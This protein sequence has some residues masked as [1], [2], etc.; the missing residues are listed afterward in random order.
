MTK[1]HHKSNTIEHLVIRSKAE[2][3]T[4][5]NPR[6]AHTH[7][8]TAMRLI[9]FG[10]N[11]L[12]R[13]FPKKAGQI[14]LNIFGTPRSRAQHKVSDDLIESA[15]VGDI[16]IDGMNIKT[17]EW[18]VGK[19]TILLA[20]GWESRGTALRAF[21]PDLVQAGYKVIAFDA[22]A[23]G[24]SE[25]GRATLLSFAEVI[26]HVLCKNTPIHAIIAHSF[27]G[28]TSIYALAQL[29]PKLVIPKLVLIA[30]PS[31]I[32]VP[33][34]EAISMMNL[35]PKAARK[36]TLNLEKIV[37]SSIKELTVPL[38]AKDLKFDN[39]LIIHDQSDLIVPINS[40]IEHSKAFKNAQLL[41][42][43]GLGHYLMLKNNQVVKRVTDF[44]L[45]PS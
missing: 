45:N 8:P 10:F 40:A 44:I 29:E 30:A 11:T 2:K 31:A 21:V 1:P 15:K 42:T 19:K 5:I 16:I 14:A 35:P 24:D 7:L 27:G 28:P 41:T 36:F 37:H 39:V 3:N 18:G 38:F 43:D 20:H 26:G 23:H 25:G 9:R 33:L 4:L 12:G 34:N 13:I 17:Y 32:S 6:I 22:P